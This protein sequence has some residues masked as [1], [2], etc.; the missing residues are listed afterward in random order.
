MK[1]PITYEYNDYG[2]SCVEMVLNYY[3]RPGYLNEKTLADLRDDHSM[4][5]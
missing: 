1:L 4:I 3:G 2:V 5:S